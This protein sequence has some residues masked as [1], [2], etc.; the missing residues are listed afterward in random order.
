MRKGHAA[1]F[2]ASQW[3][4]APSPGETMETLIEKCPSWGYL[5][6]ILGAFATSI[7]VA[8]YGMRVVGHVAR[9]VRRPEESR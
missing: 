9:R 1:G 5:V 2:D 8:G 3:A 4:S 6:L 7:V